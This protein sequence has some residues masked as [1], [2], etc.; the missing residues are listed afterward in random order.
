[1]K[2]NEL[3]DLAFQ[4]ENSGQATGNVAIEETGDKKKQFEDL[5]RALDAAAV[6]VRKA[7]WLQI[8]I[9]EGVKIA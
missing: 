9:E 1:M 6:A 8:H 2:G 3:L 5:E 7:A 4:L